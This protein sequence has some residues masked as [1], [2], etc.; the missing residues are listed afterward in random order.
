MSGAGTSLFHSAAAAA[1]PGAAAPPRTRAATEPPPSLPP[2]PTPTEAMSLE[3][4][5]RDE[6]GIRFAPEAED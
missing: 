6:R 5:I 4:L 2:P 1:A 3:G